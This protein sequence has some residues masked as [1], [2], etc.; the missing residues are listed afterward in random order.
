MRNLRWLILLIMEV[1]ACVSLS[2][3]SFAG[4]TCEPVAV[5]TTQSLLVKGDIMNT[6]D[7]FLAMTGRDIRKFMADKWMMQL[8]IGNPTD[9][10]VF[11]LLGS[12]SIVTPKREAYS[13]SAFV[14]D[15]LTPTI[16]PGSITKATFSLPDMQLSPGD[17]VSLY[18]AWQDAAGYHEA[19]WTW[20]MKY[21]PD[22]VLQMQ[23]SQQYTAQQR[24]SRSHS[25]SNWWLI[26]FV[27]LIL[28]GIGY[29][30]TPPD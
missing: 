5:P 16:P 9:S 23:T 26:L 27:L 7:A 2:Q 19:Y 13:L 11:L 14:Q 22:E 28:A 24:S 21:S 3:T 4:W 15:K 17:I 8:A 30:I 18:L 1:V 12:S 20:R 29:L 25:S 10:N 6:G